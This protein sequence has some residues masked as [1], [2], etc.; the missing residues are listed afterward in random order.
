[1]N[2]VANPSLSMRIKK[3]RS[4]VIT[5]EHG[6]FFKIQSGCVLLITTSKKGEELVMGIGYGSDS[7]YVP[8]GINVCA[9]DDT[10]LS[11]TTA[12]IEAMVSQY[13]QSIQV[14]AIMQLGDVKEKIARVTEFLKTTSIALTCPGGLLI[15]IS[16]NLLAKIIGCTRESVGRAL[17]VMEKEGMVRKTNEKG[18]IWLT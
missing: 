3:N 13:N 4:I 16:N 2:V 18:F 15:K 8:Y 17:S 5:S 12:N 9:M 6:S 1:M 14:Y 11:T 10:V 7:I